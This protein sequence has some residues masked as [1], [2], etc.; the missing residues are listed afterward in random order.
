MHKKKT[1][2][3]NPTEKRYYRKNTTLGN[4]SY[5]TDN[6]SCLCQHVEK[7]S[8][9]THLDTSLQT[10]MKVCLFRNYQIVR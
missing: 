3:M 1:L 7:S 8:N 6:N 5:L 4:V 10:P 9:K 2:T